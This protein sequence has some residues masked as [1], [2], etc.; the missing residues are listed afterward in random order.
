MSDTTLDQTPDSGDTSIR[1][2]LDALKNA[3]KEVG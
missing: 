3:M 2:K 1:T